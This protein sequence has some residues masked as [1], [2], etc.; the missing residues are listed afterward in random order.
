[1]HSIS[2]PS[3]QRKA[4]IAKWRVWGGEWSAKRKVRSVKCVKWLV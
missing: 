2:V 4:R 3:V 1:M